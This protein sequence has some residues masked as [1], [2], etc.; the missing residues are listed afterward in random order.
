MPRIVIE[1]DHF[2]K[3]LP[4]MLDP[5]TPKAHVDAVADFFAHDIPD[6]ALWCKY[7]RTRIPALSP[8]DIAFA[9]SQ[10]DFDTLLEDADAAIVESFTVTREALARARNLKAVQKFGALASGIDADA[11]RDKNVSVLTQRREGNVAVAE[12]AFAL[13]IALSKRICELNGVVTA[14]DLAAAGYPVRPYDRRYTGGS[15]Y[16]RIPALKALTG[17]TL[18]IVGLGEVGREIASRANAFGMTIVYYQRNRVSPAIECGLGAR[19]LPL[20][21]LMAASDYVVV[22]LPLNDSTRG[23]IGR[24]ELLAAKPGAVL[25]NAARAALVDCAA[26]IEAL[27]SG[28]LGGLGMDVGYEEPWKDGHP[29]LNYRKGNVILMPHTAVADRHYGLSDLANMCLCL[30]RELAARPRRLSPSHLIDRRG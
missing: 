24:A 23:I 1:S 22:Q 26:L 13:M 10:T 29:L 30:S 4:V 5:K 15:N 17:A 28:R 8:V 14:K 19:H 18:G 6:F 27:D 21:A 2:L 20:H 12:Q 9:E 3:I 25:I 7:F 16:A 11:C